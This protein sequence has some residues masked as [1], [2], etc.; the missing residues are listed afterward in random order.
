MVA[1]HS[2]PWQGPLVGDA[3]GGGGGCGNGRLGLRTIL[4]KC[5]SPVENPNHDPCT[6]GKHAHSTSANLTRLGGGAGKGGR[7]PMP[8]GVVGSIDQEVGYRLYR[9]LSAGQVQPH[10]NTPWSPF[11]SIDDLPR[12]PPPANV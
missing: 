7:G 10:L 1:W 2:G 3:R 8:A 5:C 12:G 6:R 4:H 9:M 11:G